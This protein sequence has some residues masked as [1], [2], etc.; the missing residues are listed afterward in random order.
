MSIQQFISKDK[1]LLIA[2]AGY[3]KT[4]LLAACIKCTPKNERQL[5]LT[6]THAGVASI[7]EKIKKL[8]IPNSKYH[9]ETIMGFAQKYVLA[10]YCGN[11]IRIPNLKN[12]NEYYPF[13]IREATNLFGLE[14]VKR[15]LR[16]SCQGLFVDEYQDCT[17]SQHNM[18]MVLSDTLPIHILGDP[19]Q[20]I[21]GFNEFLV[22][23]ANDLNDFE[24]V[25]E[26]NTPWRWKNNGNN[27]QLGN[28]LKVIRSKLNSTNKTINLSGFDSFD[29]IRITENDIYSYKS[30]YR[31]H[32]NN[33]ISNGDNSFLLIV[34]E[35]Y[36]NNTPKGD[37]NTRSKLK[38]QVDFSNQLV[39]LEA[40]DAKDFYIVSKNI[41]D[42]VLNISREIK[43][44][45]LMNEKLFL[46]LF[47]K[48]NLDMWINDNSLKNKGEKNGIIKNKLDEIIN[49][50]LESPSV[51]KLLNIILFMKNKM[52]FKTKRDNLLKSIIK[53][54]N[55]AISEG[56]TVYDAMI[57]LKNIIRRVGRKIDGKCIGTT[58]LT[59]GLEF[60]TVAIINA[61][62]IKDYKHFYVAITRACKK[63]VVFSERE[64]LKFN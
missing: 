60:D 52:K 24:K 42:L 2:P 10:F 41:D 43:K 59:K 29:Y 22:D 8:N 7:K 37:I 58:L 48:T 64:V 11:D 6:H 38:A 14:A 44:I 17:K 18:L 1:T 13:I 55:I 34:P 15:T 3:G 46:K 5:I 33:L 63:L 53:S 12:S 50:F 54:M 21:F 26:L 25:E 62:K 19:M 4:H 57:S 27:E 31:I 49:N 32:L 23:F 20:G 36:E 40:I 61:H 16:Y 51:K 45:K 56:K 35:Y 39:L 47:N 9:V 28:D 30:D